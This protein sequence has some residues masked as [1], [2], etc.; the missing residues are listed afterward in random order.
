M[1]GAMRKLAVVLAVLAAVAPSAACGGGAEETGL[2][3][4]TIHV[5]DAW[6]RS[7]MQDVGAVFFTVHNGAEVEDRLI[8]ASSPVAG[9]AEVHETVER[10]GEMVMQPVEAVPIPPNEEVRFE[11][12]GY[13]VMLYD[14]SEPLEVDSTITVVLEFEHAGQIPVEAIVKPYVPE[15]GMGG[16]GDE[17]GGGMTEAT[18]GM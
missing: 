8:G 16:M 15:E 11:P 2:E 3:E 9:R 4:D 7:P 1:E 10:D 17:M 14:L 6:A 18:G 5:A 13:H 12:G